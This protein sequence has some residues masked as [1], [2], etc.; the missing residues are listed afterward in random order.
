MRSKSPN[1]Q[2]SNDQRS[3]AQTVA[4]RALTRREH[5]RFELGQKLQHKGFEQSLVDEILDDLADQNLQS[6]VR[7]VEGFVR[8]R[9]NNGKG[10]RKIQAELSGR[11]V[12]SELVEQELSQIDAQVWLDSAR[13]IV[14]RKF[15]PI[16]DPNTKAKALRFLAG[17]GFTGEQAYAVCE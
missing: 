1:R 9:V 14:E 4:L 17:R 3:A 11:G 2:Q 6:D 5:S 7:F 13:D 8:N 16:N 10:P 15:A 12:D